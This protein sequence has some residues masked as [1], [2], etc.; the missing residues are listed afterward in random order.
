MQLQQQVRRRGHSRNS[1][2]QKGNTRW[3]WWSRTWVG[4]ALIWMF[5][6]LAQLPS[7]SC[8]APLCQAET[9]WLEWP[10]W[11]SSQLRYSTTTESPCRPAAT[12]AMKNLTLKSPRPRQFLTII[13]DY[14]H[15]WLTKSSSSSIFWLLYRLFTG[16]WVP[17]SYEQQSENGKTW[18]FR[19]SLTLVHWPLQLRRCWKY[20]S[21]KKVI[22]LHFQLSCQ[23][24]C[25]RSRRST[26][27]WRRNRRR[28]RNWTEF[29]IS[30]DSRGQ[31]KRSIPLVDLRRR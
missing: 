15:Q 17:K 11:W 29:A 14:H 20:S 27:I 7:Q 5:L 21:F 26:G 3:L 23:T 9:A 13:S 8:Q 2:K 18:V 22:V 6:H 4:L 25:R 12:R 10:E 31:K 30:E 24:L 28:I 16:R 1:V 19:R